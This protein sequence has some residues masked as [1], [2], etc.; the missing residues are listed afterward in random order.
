MTLDGFKYT[1]NGRGEYQ[2]AQVDDIFSFQGRMTRAV[3]HQGNPVGATVFSAVAMREGS[4]TI[5]F[6][7]GF[8]GD[9]DTL[10]NGAFI[11]LLK[12][13]LKNSME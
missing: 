11:D 13:F 2:L 3:N 6:Q 5:Q 8:A 1:F 10:I 7:V 4:N 12:Y 9:P